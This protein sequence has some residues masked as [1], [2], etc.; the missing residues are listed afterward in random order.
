MCEHLAAQDRAWLIELTSTSRPMWL[1]LLSFGLS[2]MTENSAEATRFAREEDADAVRSHL[3]L[4]R[5]EGWTVT[6]HGWWG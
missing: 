1:A 3:G 4:N 2:R 5:S 6:E